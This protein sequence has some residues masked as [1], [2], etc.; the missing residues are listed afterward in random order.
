M[1]GC[2]LPFIFQDMKKLYLIAILFWSFFLNA[3]TAY[4]RAWATYYGGNTFRFYKFVFDHTGNLYVIGQAQNAGLAEPASYYD[5]FVTPQ[6]FQPSFTEQS[7]LLFK[8]S[9]DGNLVWATY[10]GTNTNE[11]F[12]FYMAVDS[13]DNLF[14]TAEIIGLSDAGLAT[15]PPGFNIFTTGRRGLLLKFTP[16]GQRVW[17]KWLPFGATT[18]AV[19]IQDQLLI[20]GLT[21][22]EDFGTP[23]VFQ[24][25]FDSV[26]NSLAP[27]IGCYDGQGNKIWGTYNGNVSDSVKFELISDEAGNCYAWGMSFKSDNFYA[28]PGCFQSQSDY[29]LPPSKAMAYLSKFSTSG[30]RLWSTYYGLSSIDQETTFSQGVAYENGFVYIT[31][32]TGVSSGISTAGVFQETVANQIPNTGNAFVAKFDTSGNRI[33][34]SYLGGSGSDNGNCIAVSDGVVVVAGSTKS[35]DQIAT[36][37][38]LQPLLYPPAAENNRNGFINA[39]STDGTTK[40][41]GSYYGGEGISN[42]W[43]LEFDQS[44]SV[45]LAGTTQSTVNIATPGSLQPQKNNGLS[46]TPNIVNNMFIARFDPVPLKTEGFS[47]GID[48]NYFPNP[49]NSFVSITAKTPIDEISVYNVAG[50]LLYNQKVNTLNAK[51]DIESFATGTYFFQLKFGE[52]QAH[53][54][55]L[56]M[57]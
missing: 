35:P 44:G 20:G 51:V 33:W 28:S 10:L 19:D 25:T 47:S 30:Q 1:G 27:I 3:Q 8:I 26:S 56:K 15:E 9:P 48:F 21:A 40:Y 5:S 13:Q 53:F 18:I 7:G 54:K 49:A 43:G 14:I 6:C 11:I 4:E 50:Q 24:E 29:T 46:T 37:G 55:I 22:V 17:G 36:P 2:C 31:G 34:G 32:S 23:G 52:K 12:S 42:I 45:F 16:E 41:W 38:A 39:I 57:N